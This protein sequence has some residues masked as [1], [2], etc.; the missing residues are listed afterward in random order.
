MGRTAKLCIHV[1]DD[2][3]LCLLEERHAQELFDLVHA[4]RAHLRVWLPWVD[5]ETSVEDS[6]A[7]IKSSLRQFANNKGFQ[8]GI[9]YRRQLA[10]VIGYHPINWTNR[11][12]EIGYWLVESFQGRGL[13]TKACK[14]LITYAFNELEL[15]KVSIECATG[16][17]RSCAIPKR[18]GF[19]QEGILRDSEWLYDHYVDHFVFGMLARDWHPEDL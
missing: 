6:K 15:N 7:F 3:E 14:T 18:F 5:Y 10:G 12:V 16:N 17:S 19:V 8:L 9:R 4:N 11:K 13:M 2:T 1:D